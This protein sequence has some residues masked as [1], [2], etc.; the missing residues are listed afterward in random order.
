MMADSQ[1]NDESFIVPPYPL[2]MVVC[3]WIH[4]DPGTGKTTLLGLFS[5]IHAKEFPATHGLLA[6]HVAVT[7]GRGKMS[8]RLRLIDVDEERDP[9]AEATQEVDFDDPTKVME[10]AFPFINL[11][12]EK[13]GEY[14]FQLYANETPLMERR[15]LV[16]QLED[17]RP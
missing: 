6:L 3:D 14:R 17:N 13:P 15:I 1:A 7:D 5:T 11:V 2:A 8:I 9:V 16:R 12:F 4:H 10:I